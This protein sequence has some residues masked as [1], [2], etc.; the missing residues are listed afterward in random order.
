MDRPLLHDGKQRYSTFQPNT[1]IPEGQDEVVDIRTRENRVESSNRKLFLA[2]FA[3]VIGNF[4]F[5]YAMVYTSPVIPVLESPDSSFC[6]TEDEASWFGSVFTLGTAAGGLFGMILNDIVGRKLSIML[7]AVPSGIGYFIMSSAQNV[8]M[9]YGGRILTGIAGGLTSAS[10]P[11]YVSEI[12][13][14]GVRGALGACPQMMAVIGSLTLYL[15]GILLPWRWLAVVGEVP[16]IVMVIL[17]CFMPDSPRFLIS[18]GKRDQ[19]LQALCWLRGAEAN[20]RQECDQIENNLQQQGERMSCADLR[21]PSFY[22]PIRIAVSMRFLQQLTGITPILFYL[23]SIFDKTSVILPGEYDAAIVGAVRFL[24]VLVAAVLMDKAGRKCLLFASGALMFLATLML[25]LYITFT[26]PHSHPQNR[27]ILFNESVMSTEHSTDH[28]TYSPLTM[29]PLFSAIVIIMGYALGWGPITWLLMSEILPLRARGV[30][31]GLCVLVSWITAFLLTRFFMNV[32][33]HF[34]LDVPFYF[35][36]IICLV[37]LL[38][39][40]LW[41]PETKGKSLEEIEA[42][43][44]NNEMVSHAS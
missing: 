34:G 18:K 16:T 3:A 1:D 38:F 9:L 13:H 40:G 17:L 36:T 25:G 14:P 44:R 29:I 21:K 26:K 23:E 11:V 27:T 15:L 35:F 7:S 6:I 30:A 5:G 19:A 24:S 8:N 2:A 42:Y 37:N 39:T 20:Y 43:F 33:D 10:I 12:S 31:S 41:V 22:K 32:V 4:S 28:Y